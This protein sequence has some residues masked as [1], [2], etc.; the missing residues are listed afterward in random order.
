MIFALFLTIF[1]AEDH[2]HKYDVFVEYVVEPTCQ[3]NGEAIYKCACGEV[4][5]ETV[6]VPASED[7]HDWQEDERSEAATC[8]K[9]GKLVSVCTICKE[10]KEEV[11]EASD[12]YH[13]YKKK[14]TANG[15]EV[16]EC[17]YCH[18][19]YTEGVVC[20]HNYKRIGTTAT[21]TKSG[22]E[23]LRCTKCGDEKTERVSALGHNVDINN[24]S[25]LII[26]EATCTTDGKASG[27]CTRC[28]VKGVVEMVIPAAHTYINAVDNKEATC[29]EPG[30]LSQICT[31]CSED[32]PG[33]KIYEIT[34]AKGHTVPEDEKDI[35]IC[36][37]TPTPTTDKDGNSTYVKD[38]NG[39]II[40]TAVKGNTVDLSKT[41]TRELNKK[42]CTKGIVRVYTCPDCKTE[43][44]ETIYDVKGHNFRVT[45]NATCTANGTKEC[46]ICE[47]TETIPAT[48]HDLTGGYLA[49]NKDGTYSVK[50]NNKGCKTLII[51]ADQV[52]IA[53][54]ATEGTVDTIMENTTAKETWNV[55]VTYK[56][57]AKTEIDEIRITNRAKPCV[58]HN[59]KTLTHTFTDLPAVGATGTLTLTCKANSEDVTVTYTINKTDATKGTIK[60]D[61][62]DV[63]DIT[64]ATD[65]KILTVGDKK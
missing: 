48:G 56:D 2:E 22:V 53:D 14:T 44:I 11:I 24:P 60:D 15:S 41:T 39:E 19:L 3:K 51:P 9:D 64:I 40:Y 35:V 49:E 61:K 31:K 38:D 34:P 43:V 26:K 10:E 36:E 20:E 54:K 25:T 1:D 21:C 57:T 16:W 7:F 33:H 62:G 17:T 12:E 18:D 47:A 28:D 23:T 46:T 50:C 65:T 5:P 42:L 6:V 37:G 55:A 45:T 13:N 29:T 58:H 63:W 30:R 4:A 32:T 27:K 52:H 59:L 8:V